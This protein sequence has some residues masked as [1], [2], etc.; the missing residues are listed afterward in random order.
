M[1]AK[2]GL[3]LLSED[4]RFSMRENKATSRIFVLKRED[5]TGQ[6]KKKNYLSMAIQ[7]LRTLTTFPLS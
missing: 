6:R 2:L 4:H 7:P 1:T 5:V 3:W